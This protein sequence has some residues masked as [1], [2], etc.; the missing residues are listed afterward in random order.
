MDANCRRFIPQ[1]NELRRIE[2]VQ[3]T[4][5]LWQCVLNLMDRPAGDDDNNSNNKNSIEMAG[6]AFGLEKD[7]ETV[8]AQAKACYL[9]SRLMLEALKNMLCVY[10]NEYEV[11]A[12]MAMSRG[13]GGYLKQLPVMHLGMWDMFLKG[14]CLLA[15]YRIRRKGKYK[16][17][18]LKA[19][20]AIKS[21]V[22]Q[23]NPNVVHHLALLD[24]E[25]YAIKGKLD[26]ATKRYH[27]SVV[28]ASRGGFIHDAALANERYADFCI[29]VLVS[30]E[31]I[32][33]AKFR[34]QEAIRLY[35]EWGAE[36]K[37]RA[38][39]RRYSKFL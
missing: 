6:E 12:D 21:W 3:F 26:E 1:M 33:E 20:A 2:S 4:S 31:S 17:H 32:N 24:A 30:E 35:S 37:V 29:D 16:R 10:F 34:V 9:P 28:T 22:K 27:D 39:R 8:F 13:V 14:V 23:G 19:R 36:A 25:Y 11:A 7:E 18:G 38:L 5:A 15:A